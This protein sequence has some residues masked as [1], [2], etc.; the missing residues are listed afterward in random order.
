MT[1]HFCGADRDRLSNREVFERL[2]RLRYQTF[3]VGRQWTLPT[4]NGLDIDQYD[5]QHAVYF[6][7]Q[8]DDGTICAHVRLTPTKTHSLLAD[9]FPHLCEDGVDPRGDTIWECTR[10]IVRPSKKSRDKNRAAK[11]Q[12]VVTMLEWCRCNG[13]THIQTVID[14][15]TYPT[16]LEMTKETQPLGL[17]HP[18]GGGPE[19]SGGGEC[20]AWRWP[21]TQAVIDDI[22]RYG[23]LACPA[24]GLLRAGE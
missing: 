4:A 16:F 2:A 13:I 6:Y 18:F 17:S 19:V 22:R 11:A 10:Y 1:Q 24:S 20:M 9:Y 5:S 7:D 12:L 23:G 15:A 8:D 3:V 14:T 21:V